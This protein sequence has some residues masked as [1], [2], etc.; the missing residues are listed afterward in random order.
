MKVGIYIDGGYLRALTRKAKIAFSP[1]HVEAVAHACLLP[2]EDLVRAL[3]YDCEPYQGFVTLPVSKQE[4]RWE[5]DTNWV[6]KIAL[7][8]RFAVRLGT[9]KYRGFVLRSPAAISGELTDEDFRPDFVQKGVDMRLGIDI[10]RNASRNIFE[11]IILIC[12]DTDC[13]PAVRHARTE[14]TQIVTV[15]LP[16]AKLVNELTEHSDYVR[17]VA[18]PHPITRKAR[19]SRGRAKRGGKPGSERA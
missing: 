16:E 11:R 2:G 6:R 15:E 5:F 13:L 12:G 1:D 9:L 8:P 14:G 7:K 18:W 19:V 3:Y 10:V 17:K 4:V